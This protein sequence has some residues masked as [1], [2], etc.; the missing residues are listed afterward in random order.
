MF[1]VAKKPSK[2]WMWASNLQCTHTIMSHI[3]SIFAPLSKIA[4]NKTTTELIIAIF[5]VPNQS[6][7]FQIQCDVCLSRCRTKNNVTWKIIRDYSAAVRTKPMNTIYSILYANSS[8]F[9][10]IFSSSLHC[11]INYHHKL[12]K[13][14]LQ[15]TSQT[16]VCEKHSGICKN[17]LWLLLHKQ[18]WF[19]WR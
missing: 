12:P 8:H 5:S 9:N 10:L 16:N 7:P 11:Q 13:H 15:E 19:K 17:W 4:P 14:H 1:F 6:W 3:L 18:K 2:A